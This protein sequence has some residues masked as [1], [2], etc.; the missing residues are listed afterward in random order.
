M[1]VFQSIALPPDPHPKE[2]IVFLVSISQ[3]RGMPWPAESGSW[4][5]SVLQSC[6]FGHLTLLFTSHHY[7]TCMHNW[8]WALPHFYPPPFLSF[9]FL[10]SYRYWLALQV[11]IILFLVWPEGERC[12]HHIQTRPY[13]Q[14]DSSNKQGYLPQ[15]SFWELQQSHP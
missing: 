9:F 8:P 2:N 10:C 3:D 1:W 13:H 5:L 12:P 7:Q 6:G 14:M 4:I 15:G 11:V